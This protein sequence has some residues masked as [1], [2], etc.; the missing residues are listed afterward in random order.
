[1]RIGGVK[2]LFLDGRVHREHVADLRG[3]LL[4]LRRLHVFLA[5]LVLLEQRVYFV[6]I[7]L[8]KLDGVVLGLSDAEHG[9]PFRFDVTGKR[10]RPPLCGNPGRVDVA[11]PPNGLSDE[12][13]G[14]PTVALLGF[15]VAAPAGGA[16]SSSGRRCEN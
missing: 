15:V 3:E 4:L 9:Y 7:L 6:V 12:G 8:E 1:L 16:V 2:D 13:G 10:L 11:R 14:T 5:G